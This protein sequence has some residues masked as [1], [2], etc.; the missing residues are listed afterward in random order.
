MEFF[1]LYLYCYKNY[2]EVYVDNSIIFSSAK[3][4]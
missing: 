1:F 3:V 4:R 2:S